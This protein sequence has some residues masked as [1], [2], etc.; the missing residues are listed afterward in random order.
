[1][2][3]IKYI[4]FIAVFITAISCS[5]DFLDVKNL[6]QQS[7]ESYY[8]DEQDINEALTAAYAALPV[9]E[10]NNNPFI[11]SELMS[12]DCFGGGGVNDDGFHNTDAFTIHVDDYYLPLFR[13]NYEGILRV[14]MI[15]KR[16]DQAEFS[17]EANKN[18]ALGETY[19]LRAYFYFRA[20]Q[21][22]GPVPLKLDPAP[23]NLPKPTPEQLYGQIASDLKKAIELMPSTP[24]QSI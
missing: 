17:S 18:Q 24:Y 14:N 12:D 22:F 23:A 7:D 13:K 5:E 3:K 20:A 11:V 16:F 6:Y 10:G 9:N 19:F 1:M 8:N 4:A 21:F 2:K 15:L